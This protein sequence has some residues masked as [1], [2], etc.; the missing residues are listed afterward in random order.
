MSNKTIYTV[1][2]I[3]VDEANS[4]G[5]RGTLCPTW[6]DCDRSAPASDVPSVFDDT[7]YIP[8]KGTTQY[9][10]VGGRVFRE[11]YAARGWLEYSDAGKRFKKAFLNVLIVRSSM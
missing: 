3:G 6:P 9:T 10:A 2:G 11:E 4:V 8:V 7:G 5:D 1:I